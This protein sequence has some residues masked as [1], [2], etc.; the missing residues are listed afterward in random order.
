MTMTKNDHF[1][2]SK[3]LVYVLYVDYLSV[4][5]NCIFMHLFLMCQ[6]TSISSQKTPKI[7]LF[8]GL[9]HFN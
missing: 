1:L 3:L 7:E 6:K 9:I 5:L 2:I 4:R 8:H